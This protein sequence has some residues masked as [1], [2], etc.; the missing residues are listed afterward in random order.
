LSIERRI[1][2]YLMAY[3][4]TRECDLISY[5][6]QNFA[7]S[8]ETMKKTVDRMAIKGKIHRIVHNKLKPPEVYISLEESL[9]IDAVMEKQIAGDEAR[10]I[11]EE[12]ASVAER[13]SRDA[14]P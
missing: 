1:V 5:G 7:R 14:W 11:L 2:S 10:R 13:R 9:P 6:V 4:N 8:P 3:G 12:A